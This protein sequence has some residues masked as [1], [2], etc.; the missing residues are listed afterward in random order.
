MPNDYS[1]PHKAR[2]QSGQLPPSDKKTLDPKYL[3][4]HENHFD[5]NVYT[6]EQL[7]QRNKLLGGKDEVKTA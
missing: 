2:Q 7:I 4:Q 5:P 1:I 6:P 3:I